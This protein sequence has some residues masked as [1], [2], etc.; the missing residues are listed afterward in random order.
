MALLSSTKVFV[1]VVRRADEPLG[2][3]DT[4]YPQTYVDINLDGDQYHFS[5]SAAKHIAR[6]LKAAADI[7]EPPVR[8]T[9]KAS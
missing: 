2:K 7:I 9:R 1:G 5:P 6:A 3:R 8:R 4:W